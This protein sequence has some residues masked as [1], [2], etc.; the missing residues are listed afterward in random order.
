MFRYS[1]I[2]LSFAILSQAAGLV[3][4]EGD[5]AV[6]TEG[7]RET[8]QPV[9]IASDFTLG[10]TDSPALLSSGR[11]TVLDSEFRRLNDYRLVFVRSD[12][13]PAGAAP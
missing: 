2:L 12:A 11:V 5:A 9:Y 8:L 1:L 13:G 10:V 6:F 4:V 7:W 3:M